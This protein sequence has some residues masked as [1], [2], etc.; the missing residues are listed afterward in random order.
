LIVVT[1]V[2]GLAAVAWEPARPLALPL[3]VVVSLW[4]AQEFNR[5]VLYARGSMASA[6]ANNA[7]NY[8]L[9][10]PL[11]GVV[12][13]L[14][15]L[16]LPVALWIMA[17]TS[18]LA[19]L[20]GA[21]QL[22]RFS[23]GDRDDLGRVVRDASHIAKWTAPSSVFIAIATQ[24]YPAFVSALV[25]LVA[26]G[27]LGVIN[28]ILN[29][30]NLLTRPIQNYYVPLAVRALSH[31]GVVGLNYVLKRAALLMVPAYLLYTLVLVAVPS[32]ILHAIY[33]NRYAE[34]ADV[35]RVFALASS[36][37]IPVSLLWLELN[38]RRQQKYILVGEMWLALEACVGGWL[39][40]DH[41]G[42]VGVAYATGIGLV[43]QLMLYGALVLR[44]RLAENASP[45]LGLLERHA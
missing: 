25:G 1:A 15:A 3:M 37:Y 13:F 30:V 41:F 28:Q 5:R 9:Q 14:G 10:V 7:I 4:Q 20:L 36:I 23:V 26:A 2:I 11:L 24:W 21:W 33:G 44:A 40:I 12:A 27:A 22:R 43:G 16:T 45:G 42:I 8:D 6:A 18:L 31:K 38:A 19:T 35:L 39:L 34:Y 32:L 17:L 29:P